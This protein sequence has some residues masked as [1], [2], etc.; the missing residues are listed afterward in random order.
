MQILTLCKYNLLFFKDLL[1]K[2]CYS[3]IMHK[4]AEHKV[5]RKDTIAS[6]ESKFWQNIALQQQ[7]ILHA[8]YKT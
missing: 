3:S 5:S 8:K 1:S 6:R 7:R 2:I 4:T